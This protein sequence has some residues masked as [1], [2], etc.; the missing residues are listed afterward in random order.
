[1]R[2]FVNASCWSPSQWVLALKADSAS[3]IERRNEQSARQLKNH[4]NSPIEPC[5]MR[6]L[7]LPARGKRTLDLRTRGAKSLFEISSPLGATHG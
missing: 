2:L 6:S 5:A 7:A 4:L 1:M 3:E